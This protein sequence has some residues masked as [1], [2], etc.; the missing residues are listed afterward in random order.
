MATKVKL[1]I[2]D[3]LNLRDKLDSVYETAS[4][5]QVARWALNLATHILQISANEYLNNEIIKNG[6]QVNY[7]WQEEKANMN[8]VRQAGFKVHKLAKQCQDESIR[9]ALRVVGHCVATGHMKEHGMIG[10]DYAIKYMNL[11]F[12]NNNEAVKKERE[13]QID[14]LLSHII[15]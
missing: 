7:L 6:F 14:C 10:S 12:P 15:K 13:W 9:I 2:N 1:K 5:I 11:V 3:N 4:K 8:N